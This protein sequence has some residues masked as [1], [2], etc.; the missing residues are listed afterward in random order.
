ML[1][2]TPSGEYW[3]LL[4]A[5]SAKNRKPYADNPATIN[6][7]PTA[8]VPVGRGLRRLAA[9]SSAAITGEGTHIG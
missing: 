3:A 5:L 1:H 9:S 2:S 7:T 6:P 8:A 4:S